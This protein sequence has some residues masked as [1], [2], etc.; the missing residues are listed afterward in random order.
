MH[1]Y[2][3][4]RLRYSCAIGLSSGSATRWGKR[5]VVAGVKSRCVRAANRSAREAAR[6]EA[7]RFLRRKVARHPPMRPSNPPPVR[8]ARVVAASGAQPG[9][10]QARRQR[11]AAGRCV[12]AAARRAAEER[13]GARCPCVDARI[14]RPSR[15]ERHLPQAVAALSYA[16]TRTVPMYAAQCTAY[17]RPMEPARPTHRSSRRSAPRIRPRDA[18]SRTSPPTNRG[19]PKN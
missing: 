13:I 9:A 15:Q 1:P 8:W 5:R 12:L 16:E 3:F 4:Q 7:R 6:G 17:S 19:I 18:C 14:R 10:V 11:W 2:P